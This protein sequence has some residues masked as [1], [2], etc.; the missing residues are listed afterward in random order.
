MTQWVRK[1]ESQ[2]R[3]HPPS[4]FDFS[5][6]EKYKCCFS[7]VWR[8]LDSAP[9]G[10]VTESSL[11][12]WPFHGPYVSETDR[13]AI[14]GSLR[15]DLSEHSHQTPETNRPWRTTACFYH[16]RPV[17]WDETRK[18]QLELKKR[19]ST[20]VS[21]ELWGRPSHSASNTS[22]FSFGSACSNPPAGG[23]REPV[24]AEPAVQP[25]MELPK[26]GRVEV[27]KGQKAPQQPEAGSALPDTG[28]G[29]LT[30]HGPDHHPQQDES[31]MFQTF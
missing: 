28:G 8:R 9:L 29:T 1:S 31:W 17:P 30:A 13:E 16:I 12:I 22:C 18:K 11:S 15:P 21:M 23:T 26:K 5:G 4:A 10:S 6:D 27:E 24:P 7:T 25:P 3:E 19:R 2:K 14:T 20:I